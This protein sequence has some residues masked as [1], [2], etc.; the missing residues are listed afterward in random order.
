MQSYTTKSLANSY[1]LGRNYTGLYVAVPKQKLNNFPI[2]IFYKDESMILESKDSMVTELSFKDKFGKGNY[3][4][5]YFLWT[6]VKTKNIP[7]F[8]KDTNTFHY[9]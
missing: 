1:K 8:N 2:Q 6:P 9:K 3:T 4:L 7:I 5:C